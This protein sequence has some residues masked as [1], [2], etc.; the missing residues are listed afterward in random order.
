MC[1]ATLFVECIKTTYATFAL[2]LPVFLFTDYLRYKPIIVLE[3]I[4]YI[5]TWILLLWTKGVTAMQIMQITYG[6][7]V[8]TEVSYYTYIYAKVMNN[9]IYIYLVCPYKKLGNIYEKK[10]HL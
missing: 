4:S 1:F 5:A 6:I 8:S 10:L 9:Y 3:G 2:V 7:A